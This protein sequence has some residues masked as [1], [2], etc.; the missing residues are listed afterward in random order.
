MRNI[1][2]YG[3]MGTGKSLIGRMIATHYGMDFIEMDDQ[4]EQEEALSISAIFAE[5]GEDYFRLCERNLVKK[6][7]KKENTV[8]STGGGVVL[9]KENIS[10]FAKGGVGICLWARPEVILKRTKKGNKRP[11]LLVKNPIEEINRLLKQ[12]DPYYKVVTHH[13][14]TSLA[15]PQEVVEK[16]KNILEK[17]SI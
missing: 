3:F 5:K 14:D 17:E 2:I 8:I 13:V 15:T 1:V 12:R 7:A 10:D 9:N 4:I 6:L 11:L 16:I